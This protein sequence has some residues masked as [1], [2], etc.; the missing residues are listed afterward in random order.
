M[1]MGVYVGVCVKLL[2]NKLVIL[3]FHWCNQN[4]VKR[5]YA[6]IGKKRKKT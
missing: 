4:C 1:C 6:A 2:F 5:L 3:D